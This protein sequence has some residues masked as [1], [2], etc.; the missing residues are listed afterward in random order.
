MDVPAGLSLYSLSCRQRDAQQPENQGQP[1]HW[2][3][4]LCSSGQ[5]QHY[6]ADQGGLGQPEVY[7]EHVPGDPG[8]VG[9]CSGCG[10]ILPRGDLTHNGLCPQAAHF[11][12]LWQQQGPGR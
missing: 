5:R 11:A 1:V 6:R 7:C 10:G 4:I 3:N 2:V 12:P 8:G 9:G